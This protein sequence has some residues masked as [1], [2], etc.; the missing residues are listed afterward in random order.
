MQDI[1]IGELGGEG[2]TGDV[3]S[4][5]RQGAAERIGREIVLGEVGVD[6][7]ADRRVRG[8]QLPEQPIARAY[9]LGEQIL[10]RVEMSIEGTARQAG[11]QHD[12][13]DA[14]PS[15]AALPEKT[16]GVL[17]DLGPDSGSMGGTWRHYMSIIISYA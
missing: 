6:C 3:A 11:R 16:S 17:E 1:C 12:V 9:N 2:G 4:E 7:A 10:L 14:R 8:S 5:Y 15:V 13:V